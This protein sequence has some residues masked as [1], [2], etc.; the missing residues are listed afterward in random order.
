MLDPPHPSPPSPWGQWLAGG[1]THPWFPLNKT[2]QLQSKLECWSSEEAPG[3]TSQQQHS[4]RQLFIWS[5]VRSS[6]PRREE[7][8]LVALQPLSLRL[9]CRWAD[10]SSMCCLVLGASQALCPGFLWPQ[11]CFA[12]RGELGARLCCWA[13]PAWLHSYAPPVALA[14]AAVRE[15]NLKFELVF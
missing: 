13:W 1:L 4:A 15:L 12:M 14:A 11:S 2:F 9:G 5:S 10:P 6:K 7:W 8:S 3:Q